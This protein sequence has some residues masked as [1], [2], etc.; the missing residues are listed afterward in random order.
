M[1]DH[2]TIGRNIRLT[3]LDEEGRPVGES[4]EIRGNAIIDPENTEVGEPPVLRT[5]ELEME[6]C[7]PLPEMV[8]F[9]ADPEGYLLRNSCPWPRLDFSEVGRLPSFIKAPRDRKRRR[10]AW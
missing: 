2:P 3:R 9:V 5:F 1:T 6:F 7:D 4:F 10:R 8:E